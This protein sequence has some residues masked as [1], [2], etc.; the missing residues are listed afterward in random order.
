LQ[1]VSLWYRSPELL[2]GEREYGGAVDIWSVGCIYAEMLL[3]RSL[4]PG[5]NQIDQLCQIFSHLG[6]PTTSFTNPA[7]SQSASTSSPSAINSLEWN[8]IL[9][10]PHYH[11]TSFP[12]FVAVSNRS[13]L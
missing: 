4:F 11:R 9:S 2:L 10:L 5:N 8:D 3:G 13:V 12:K 6:T 1:V 7:S